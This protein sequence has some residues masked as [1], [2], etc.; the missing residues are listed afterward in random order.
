MDMCNIIIIL[1]VLVYIRNMNVMD[2]ALAAFLR[3]MENLC[4]LIRFVF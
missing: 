3:Y 2:F 4:R 1:W